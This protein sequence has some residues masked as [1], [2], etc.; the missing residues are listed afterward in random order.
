M[1]VV[2]DADGALVAF[3]R[4]QP[5]S[6]IA[7]PVQQRIIDVF[8]I[9]LDPSIPSSAARVAVAYGMT[10]RGGVV[11]VL[12]L[13]SC[14]GHVADQNP[15]ASVGTGGVVGIGGFTAAGGSSAAAATG[16]F[17]A[18]FDEPWD[19]G[20]A[21]PPKPEELCAM[22]GISVPPACTLDEMGYRLA[23]RWWHCS[24]EFV[25]DT[26]DSVGIEITEEGHWYLLVL[27]AAGAIV[28]GSGPSHQGTWE[29]SLPLSPGDDCFIQ[30]EFHQT[31]MLFSSPQ[32]SKHPTRVNLNTGGDG[33]APVY[34]AIP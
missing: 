12:M 17:G 24:G 16:G 11:A 4:V 13:A 27:D 18:V 14:G 20:T 25:F 21:G 30:V 8:P 33:G 31:G 3:V 29:M 2:V 7:A 28:R 32:F 9:A 19:P 10:K 1:A 22:N 26:D 15:G 5:M 23:R 6:T 34:I